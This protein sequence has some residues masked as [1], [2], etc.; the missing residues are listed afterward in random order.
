MASSSPTAPRLDDPGPSQRIRNASVAASYPYYN[1]APFSGRAIHPFPSGTSAISSTSVTGASGVN[2]APLSSIGYQP[3][4]RRDR[5]RFPHEGHV[6]QV[7]PPSLFTEGAFDNPFEVTALG[8]GEYANDEGIEEVSIHT[9][10][11]S[12]VNSEEQ[13]GSYEYSLTNGAVEMNSNNSI[14]LTSLERENDF[15]RDHLGE[16][17]STLQQAV[18][19][20][21]SEPRARRKAAIS[22]LERISTAIATDGMGVQFSKLEDND[23]KDCKPSAKPLRHSIRKRSNSDTARTM[24][25]RTF[26]ETE[27]DKTP[28]TCC[29]CLDFPKKEELASISGCSHPFCFRCIEK[30]ADRENTCP[31]C[32]SRFVKIERVHTGVSRS[33]K[34]KS[35]ATRNQRS[36]FQGTLDGILGKFDRSVKV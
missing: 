1:A 17:T 13:E 7:G 25:K 12:G 30:W 4:P 27:E 15:N 24:K 5:F 16:A 18:A 33:K 34:M 26:K 21:A 19:S 14:E 3:R 20:P 28:V 2:A 31:L 35:V 10:G 11:F 32:K 6:T 22:C 29:I 9:I 23:V 36:D 8:H